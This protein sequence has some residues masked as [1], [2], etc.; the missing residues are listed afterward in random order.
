AVKKFC[1]FA[2]DHLPK[3]KNK[4]YSDYKLAEDEWKLLD[5]I[6]EVLQFA[7]L[8]PAIKK[9]IDKLKK[10]HKNVKESDTYFTC[11]ALHPGIK[12]D[13]CKE[14]WDIEA[15]ATGYSKLEKMVRPLV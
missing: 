6:K 14:K 7:S 13:Y 9:G 12:L 10:W 11:L 3:L 8:C 2:D 5:L 1:F 15:Y 4:S